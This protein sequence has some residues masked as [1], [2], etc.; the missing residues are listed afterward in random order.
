MINPATMPSTPAVSC[1]PHSWPVPARAMAPTPVTILLNSTKRPNTTIRM[2][3]VMLGQTSAIMPNITAS[4]PLTRYCH[5]FSLA[6]RRT[7]STT[8]LLLDQLTRPTRSSTPYGWAARGYA[9]L[10][11]SRSSVASFSL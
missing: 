11:M 8:L 4:T 10:C 2:A 5:Q 7:L 6:A 9:S 1:Q 3:N